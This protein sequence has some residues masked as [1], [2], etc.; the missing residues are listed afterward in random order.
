M[1]TLYLFIVGFAIG[2][3]AAGLLN[4]PRSECKNEK[5]WHILPYEKYKKN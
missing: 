3:T 5:P 4:K 1:K 2:V